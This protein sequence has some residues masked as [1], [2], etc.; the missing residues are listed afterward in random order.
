[1][2]RRVAATGNALAGGVAPAN[3]NNTIKAKRKRFVMFP[4][5]RCDGRNRWRDALPT[6]PIIYAASSI[7]VKEPSLVQYLKPGTS[8]PGDE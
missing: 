7:P 1:M 5:N 2:S 3:E 8:R 4:P 6:R